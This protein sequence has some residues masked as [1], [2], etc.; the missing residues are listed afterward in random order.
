MAVPPG[1]QP[2]ALV[3]A[4]SA[5]QP[6]IHAAGGIT[7][8]RLTALWRRLRRSLR[9]QEFGERPGHA[10]RAVGG[11]QTYDRNQGQIIALPDDVERQQ[12]ED[13]G[14]GPGARDEQGIAP[15]R[16]ESV[17]PAQQR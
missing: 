16:L 4:L 10:G 5:L 2:A 6:E 15:L 17:R 13:R 3:A 7:V 11:P 9:G 12:P 1:C 8:G 14:G